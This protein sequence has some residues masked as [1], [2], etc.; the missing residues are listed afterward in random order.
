MGVLGC[1]VRGEAPGEERLL[2][3]AL[4]S[5]G[6]A[7]SQA[8]ALAPSPFS[9]CAGACMPTSKV[10]LT[11]KS[12]HRITRHEVTRSVIAYGLHS[13]Y[14]GYVSVSVTLRRLL[15]S[16]STGQSS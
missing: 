13:M 3:L 9:G 5:R 6:A 12:Y 2:R 4:R 15:E 16:G 7:S 10:D 1:A 14:N 8:A 11:C